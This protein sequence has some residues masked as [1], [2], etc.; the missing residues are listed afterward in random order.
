M[1]D[2]GNLNEQLASLHT[3]SVEIAGLHNMA[4]I[5]ERALGYCLMLTSSEF[6]FTGLLRDANVGVVASGELEASEY[7]MDVAAIKGFVASPS[8]YHMFHLMALRSSVVGVA[9]REDRPCIS[10]DVLGDR[11]SVGQ[12]E[13]HPPIRRFLGV[14]LRLRGK[15]I[16]MIGVA[17]KPAGYGPEDERLLST[18][19][20]QMAVAVGNARLYEG[21]RRMIAELQE[22]HKRLTEAER[23][24]LLGRERERIAGAFHDRI[25]Q[26]IFSICVRLNALLEDRAMGQRLVDQLEEIRRL[27]IGASYEVR[28]AIFALTT[29]DHEKLDLADRVRSLLHEL[30]RSSGIQAH[31]SLNGEP[32]AAVETVSDVVYLVIDE[33]L[34]NVKKHSHARMVLVSLR[35]EN[36][37]LHFVVQDDGTGAPAVLLQT[38]PDSYLH[39]GLRHIRQLVI[40]RGGTFAVT[41]GEEA[42]LVLKVS[43]PLKAGQ[44]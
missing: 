5:H 24:Q 29:P 15:V 17:N 41:N 2:E 44:Q 40:D 20:A 19:A 11:R 35:F 25:E 16:G 3:I 42:G 22:L 34:T 7:V 32:T 39:F 18:F 33:A 23:A 14:P 43:I 38:F 1:G 13:G 27:S 36:D 12:P 10:N 26:Q 28:R 6:A 4:E 31:L 30:E 21:Q 9:V 37:H 8:F